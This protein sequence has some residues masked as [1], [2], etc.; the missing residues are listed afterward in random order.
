[1]K[2]QE[3]EEAIARAQI[4]INDQLNAFKER[5]AKAT[6]D[7]EHFISMT[8]LEKEWQQLRLSTS[9]TYSDLVSKAISSFDNKDL[10]ALKKANSSR[11]G[12]D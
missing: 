12:S 8:E 3:I 7:P 1:M 6:A 9:K 5:L 4:E 11:K 10:N 2:H